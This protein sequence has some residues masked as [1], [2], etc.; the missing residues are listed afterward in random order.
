MNDTITYGAKDLTDVIVRSSE[1]E[2]LGER[3]ILAHEPLLVFDEIHYS[4][5]T[6][7][8]RTVHAKGGGGNRVLVTWNTPQDAIF[9][10]SRG[11]FTAADL[12]MIAGKLEQKSSVLVPNMEYH[13]VSDNLTVAPE[14][15]IELNSLYVYLFEDEAINK[16]KLNEDYNVENN[17][18]I[19]TKDDY[20][21]KFVRLIYDYEYTNKNQVITVGRPTLD[22]YLE[23]TGKTKFVEEITKE[24][25]TAI[26]KIPKASIISDLNVALGTEVNPARLGFTLQAHPY[27][28][29]GQEHTM[30]IIVL[31]G[32]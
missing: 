10:F 6:A 7:N 28:A 21:S 13:Q 20:R 2:F 22:G 5:I 14:Q 1:P 11:V 24:E 31:T 17:I 23:V 15:R 30:E 29:R 16:L 26:I 25:R 8:S 4:T 19:F 18:I 9:E 3:V 32:D 12:G 27:G